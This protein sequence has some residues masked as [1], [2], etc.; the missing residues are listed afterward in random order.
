MYGGEK[1]E[2]DARVKAEAAERGGASAPA[3]RRAS[4]TDIIK[5]SKSTLTAKTVAHKV[6]VL[7]PGGRLPRNQL[8][9]NPYTMLRTTPPSTRKAAPVVPEARGLAT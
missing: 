8:S 6:E 7:D 9:W 2:P 3:L 5:A 4:G 1:S